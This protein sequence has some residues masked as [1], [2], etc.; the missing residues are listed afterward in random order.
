MKFQG[1]IEYT[2][3]EHSS[4]H[5][6]AEMPVRAGILN[7]DGVVN[8]GAILWFADACATLLAHGEDESTTAV[9][10]F[11]TGISINADIVGN[12]RDGVLRALSKFIKNGSELNTVHTIITG[13][14]EML[15][16]DITTRY[17]VSK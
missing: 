1:E 16:A 17:I 3:T 13:T 11:L 4:E 5:V 12:Q 14:D 9:E 7:L 10:G 8:H 15:I 2:I 6:L